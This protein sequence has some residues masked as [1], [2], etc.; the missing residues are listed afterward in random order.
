MIVGRW[1][2][3]TRIL[4]R[5]GAF[6]VCRDDFFERAVRVVVCSG[7]S[8]AVVVVVNHHPRVTVTSPAT[9]ADFVDKGAS[10]RPSQTHTSPLRRREI[11]NH[12]YQPPPPSSYCARATCVDGDGNN[13]K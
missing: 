2:C 10:V 6:Q 13:N 5:A 7:R 9:T 4:G 8:S 1:W 3:A 12:H 11:H